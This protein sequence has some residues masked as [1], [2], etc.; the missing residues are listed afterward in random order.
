[1]MTTSLFVGR[2]SV[3]NAS[4]GKG[5][6]WRRLFGFL[7]RNSEDPTGYFGVPPGR[8]VEMGAQLTL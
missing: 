3:V 8:V 1:M 7:L 5:P 4:D 2:R 6:R